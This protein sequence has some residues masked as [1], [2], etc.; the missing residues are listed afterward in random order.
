MMSSTIADTPE[1]P[2]DD[3]W[4]EWEDGDDTEIYLSGYR[5]GLVRAVEIVESA[6]FQKGIDEVPPSLILPVIIATFR[7]IVNGEEDD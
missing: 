6:A 4:E 1:E 5:D 3:S 2:F 7:A